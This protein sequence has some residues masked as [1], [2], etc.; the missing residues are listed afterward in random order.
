MFTVLVSMKLLYII[1]IFIYWKVFELKGIKL[2]TLQFSKGLLVTLIESF[3]FYVMLLIAKG[4]KIV[5]DEVDPLDMNVIPLPMQTFFFIMMMFTIY[6][7][8][9]YFLFIAIMYI[10][11]TPKIFS[12]ISDT[13]NIL[14]I[15]LW[16]VQLLRA[17]SDAQNSLKT[18][19]FLYKAFRIAVIVYTLASIIMYTTIMFITWYYEWFPMLAIEIISFAIFTVIMYMF[20]PHHSIDNVEIFAEDALQELLNNPQFMAVLR[21]RNELEDLKYDVNNTEVIEWPDKTIS[22]CIKQKVK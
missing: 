21:S 3:L 15:K 6:N 14:S 19:I 5:Y 22:L 9:Y 8:S 2:F 11:I 18:K 4:Y 17:N 16:A 12:S 7:N 13:L 10:L 20:S 1:I